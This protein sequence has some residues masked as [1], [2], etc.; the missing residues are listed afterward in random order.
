M[1]TKATHEISLPS[2]WQG[3]DYRHEP[4]HHTVSGAISLFLSESRDGVC[5]MH[6]KSCGR[7]DELCEAVCT[8]DAYEIQQ[9]VLTMRF[10]GRLRA[11]RYCYSTHLPEVFLLPVTLRYV[12]RM[13]SC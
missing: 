13:L 3:N 8:V 10:E 1:G 5:D 6:T 11:F 9:Y 4:L 12:R 2:H 7:D